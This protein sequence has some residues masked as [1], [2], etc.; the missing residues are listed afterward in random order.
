ML[1]R[2]FDFTFALIGLIICTPVLLLLIIAIKL[3][4][5]G[6]GIFSQQRLGKCKSP[7]I[8][9]K[10]RTMRRET[11]DSLSHEISKNSVTNLGHFLRRSKI[12]ELPQLWNI[13]CG[14]MSFVGPRP[15]LIFDERLIEERQAKN[16]FSIRPGITGISQIAGID[17]SDPIALAETDAIY[18]TKQSL[19]FDII[20]I[21]KTATGAGSGD[22]IKQ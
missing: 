15:G 8:L 9:R 20:V 21:L 5:P 16:I 6:P 3:E 11:G 13:L 4:S 14:E 17:M 18:L 1:K 19:W 12:D 22:R 7:F 10:L 2:I